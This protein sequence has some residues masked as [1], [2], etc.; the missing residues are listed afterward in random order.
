MK[1]YVDKFKMSS[2]TYLFKDSEGRELI[3]QNKQEI[4]T[5]VTR[6]DK[7]LESFMTDVNEKFAKLKDRKFI[8]MTDS[9]GVDESVGGSSFSTLLE[10]MIPKSIYAY[11]WSV[12]GAGFGWPSDKAENFLN[13][14][15]SNTASWTQEDKN[16]ITDLYVF[17]GANDGN[18]LH[19]SMATDDQIRSRL[20]AF[21]N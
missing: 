16:S 12:G 13:I 15:N 18:L 8:L 3:K 17:G 10:S 14:F 21:S 6:I 9:Y 4:D 11:N 19:A 1:Q 7:E 2:G 20:D 5:T